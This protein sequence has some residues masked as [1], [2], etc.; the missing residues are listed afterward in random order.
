MIV[1]ITAVRDAKDAAMIVIIL[2]IIFLIS[3]SDHHLA[4]SDI[5]LYIEI[6]RGVRH[7][8]Q[9]NHQG[10][11]SDAEDVVMIVVMTRMT[12][13]SRLSGSIGDAEDAAMIVIVTAVG[14]AKD[15]TMIVII[16]VIIFLII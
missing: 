10:T 1:L 13:T 6:K 16:L 14:D 12:T 2:V 9:C 4:S 7:P 5:L 11:S 8:W 15:A 3:S